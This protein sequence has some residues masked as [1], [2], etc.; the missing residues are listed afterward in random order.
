MEMDVKDSFGR[1]LKTLRTHRKLSRRYVAQQLGISPSTLEKW[2]QGYVLPK[3]TSVDE[4]IRGMEL[5]EEQGRFLLEA[6]S[7]I[8]RLPSLHNLPSAENPYFTGRDAIL[9]RLHQRLTPGKPIALTQAITGLGG[10]GKTQVALHY[11]YRFQKAYSHIFWAT[12]DSEERLTTEFVSLARDM[13]LLEKNKQDQS[14]ILKAM[15]QWLREYHNWLLILDNVEEL[16]LVHSF[17]PTGHLG[18]VLLTTRQQVTG[19]VAQASLLDVLSNDEA[20][21][22]LLKRAGRLDLDESLNQATK[23]E[24]QVAQAI[25]KRLGRLPLALDQAGAYIS[26]TGCSLSSYLDRFEQEQVLFLQMRGGTP[27]DHPS[28]VTMT[29]D[30]ALEKVQQENDAAIELLKLCAFLAPDSIP[31]EMITGAATYLG[32]VLE[33]VAVTPGLLDQVVATLKKYS[34]IQRDGEKRTLSIHRLV[35]AVLYNAMTEQE[36]K[37]WIKRV[38]MI[39]HAVFPEVGFSTWKDCERLLPHVLVIPKEVDDPELANVLKKAAD[40]MADRAQYKPAEDLYRRALDIKTNA[41]GDAHPEITYPLNGL[42]VLYVDQSRYDEAEP[43]YQHC[44][45]IREQHLG[46]DHPDIARS[47]NNLANLYFMQS[48]Y[49]KAE[50]LYQ[51]C[52]SFWEQSRGPHHSDTAYPLHG[53]ANVYYELGK[54]KEAE[55]LYQRCLH[56]REQSLGSDHLL[57]TYPMHGLANVYYELGKHEEAELL[58]QR[59]LHIRER[60]QG[61]DHPEVVYPLYGLANVSCRLRR[62]KEAESLYQRCLLIW[63]KGFE[64]NHSQLAYPLNSLA[65]LYRDLGR[66]KEAESFYERALKIREQHYGRD[67]PATAESLHD[68]AVLRETQGNREE[69][70]YFYEQSLMIRKQTLRDTHP[71]TKETRERYMALLQAM[72][73]PHEAGEMK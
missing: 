32:T 27:A 22:L 50:P 26:E 38:V 39:L 56:I 9:E 49:E 64:S 37:E 5:S 18:F 8:R 1:V 47:L 63:E 2:E 21:L 68:F 54:Y 44:L 20:I 40:Y 42:A 31:L 55:P 65:N 15:Q 48:K 45:S 41:F 23:E 60:S 14:D 13:D 30:L 46:P 67:H 33:P 66:Y 24:V 58:Y 11:A 3:R 57:I 61:L 52:L 4:L 69:A 71:R 29:F 59:C 35:Q 51:R 17:V 25:T 36:R 43:L 19:S 62:Y 10:I 6:H 70:R 28:P 73:L 72:G 53:L 34:L 12:A 16:E 7:G